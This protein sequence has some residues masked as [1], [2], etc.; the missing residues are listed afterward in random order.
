[1]LQCSQ[2]HHCKVKSLGN[3][4]GQVNRRSRTTSTSLG[5][6][7]DAIVTV[8]AAQEP[9]NNFYPCHSWIYAYRPNSIVNFQVHHRTSAQASFTRSE[10]GKQGLPNRISYVSE[11]THKGEVT[12]VAGRTA[13]RPNLRLRLVRA[14]MV[15]LHSP[16]ACRERPFFPENAGPNLC[17]PGRMRL[18]S[19]SSE[20]RRQF[21]RQPAWSV[22]RYP[23]LQRQ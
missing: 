16:A 12:N 9:I 21:R 10:A 14:A 7:C 2:H 3:M 11:Q 4:E 23:V 19:P 1:V 5:R 17:P 18:P 8:F 15:R 6:L 13:G 20:P 22:L